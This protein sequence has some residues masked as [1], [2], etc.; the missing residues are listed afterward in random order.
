M[1]QRDCSGNF[2]WYYG[3]AL[4]LGEFFFEFGGEFVDVGGFAEALHLP[5]GGSHVHAG[6]LT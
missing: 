2:P 6:V 1:A 4:L 5:G 3:A